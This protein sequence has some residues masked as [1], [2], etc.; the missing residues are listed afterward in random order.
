MSTYLL[1]K[2][3]PKPTADA[4]APNATTHYPAAGML[5]SVDDLAKYMIALDNDTLL[6]H[7]SYSAMTEPFVRNDGGRAH[8]RLGGVQV[9]G[10]EP[11]HWAYGYGTLA[12]S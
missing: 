7:E 4:S 11:V 3:H 8:T 12:G 9:I 6:T 10:G 1:D 2:T 5:S